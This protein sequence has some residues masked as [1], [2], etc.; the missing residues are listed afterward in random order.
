[1]GHSYFTV[2][3]PNLSLY[4]KSRKLI[5]ALAFHLVDTFDSVD[6]SSSSM[7]ASRLKWTYSHINLTAMH[8]RTNHP[9]HTTEKT[10]SMDDALDQH[11]LNS[12]GLFEAVQVR[13]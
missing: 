5:R 12:L 1:M 2:V 10:K 3:S 4:Y 13:V 9:I 11:L 8:A 6:F 7:G